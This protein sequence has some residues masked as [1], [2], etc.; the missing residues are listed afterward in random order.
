MEPE[1]YVFGFKAK[2]GISS[3]FLVLGVQ[4]INRNAQLKW[5]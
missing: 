3:L 1:T 5:K 4:R 2:T